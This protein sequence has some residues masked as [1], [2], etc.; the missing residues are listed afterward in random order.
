M[1]PFSELAARCV[2]M[3][4]QNAREAS[5]YILGE[6]QASGRTVFV[7]ALQAVELQRA[8]TTVGLVSMFEAALQDAL[9]V[10]DGFKAARAVLQE[11]GHADLDTRF[12]DLL[13]AINVLKHGAGRSHDALIARRHA[14]PFRV[15]AEDEFL[16]EGDVSELNFLIKADEGF[17]SYSATV[18]DQVT[19]QIRIA[20]PDVFL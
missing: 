3:T 4:T 8:M 5:E 20:R 18:V 9:D 19:A 13:M 2:A 12:S 6:L 1:H 7:K 17:L 10:E 15:R 14:L 16:E 11:C